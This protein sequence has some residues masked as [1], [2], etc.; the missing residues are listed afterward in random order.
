M[1][2]KNKKQYYSTI[3]IRRDIKEHL[4]RYCDLRGLKI[5]RYMEQLFLSDFS[6]SLSGS[7][8]I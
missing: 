3:Q 1:S 7:V 8:N 6:G 2:R 5:S 4:T